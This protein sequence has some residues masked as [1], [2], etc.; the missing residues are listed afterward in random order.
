MLS[1]IFAKWLYQ[2]T[3]PLR[4]LAAPYSHQHLVVS[5]LLILAILEVI[6]SHC[7]FKLHSPDDNHFEHIFICLLAIWTYPF[8]IGL[9][10]PLPIS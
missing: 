1:N 9:F 10:S 8:V 7:G 2:S 3:L 5:V 4:V 6:V